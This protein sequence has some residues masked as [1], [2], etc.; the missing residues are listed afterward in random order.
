[1]D[2]YIKFSCKECDFRIK[3][4]QE[5]AG[6][7]GKCPKCKSVCIIPK[8]EYPLSQIE[9]DLA[10]LGLGDALSASGTKFNIQEW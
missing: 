9:K 6:K 10:E 4:L 8:E 7:K 1:M 3:T 2:E 5:H